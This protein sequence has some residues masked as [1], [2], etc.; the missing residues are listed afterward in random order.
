MPDESLADSVLS[1]MNKPK[2]EQATPELGYIKVQK[3]ETFTLTC[4]EL[5]AVIAKN[6][7]HPVAQAY[8]KAV[9][10]N[11]PDEPLIIEKID[12]QAMIDNKEVELITESGETEIDG[13]KLPANFQVKR[14]GK[15]YKKPERQGS[16][17][18]PENTSLPNSGKN[19]GPASDTNAGEERR[20]RFS[21]PGTKRT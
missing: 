17:F 7:D 15:E 16:R 13:M 12:L 6:P 4:R 3:G 9:K 19:E 1:R 18:S 14:L 11:P 5:A 10:K 21:S 20:D 8:A 2:E